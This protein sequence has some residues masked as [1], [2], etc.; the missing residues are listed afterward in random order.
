MDGRNEREGSQ[1]SRNGRGLDGLFPAPTSDYLDCKRS[2]AS[3]DRT[4]VVF[5][6]VLVAR[7][8]DRAGETRES[9]VDGKCFVA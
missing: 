9:R 6:E 3:L 7:G 8:E 4:V 5:I 1:Q 2:I